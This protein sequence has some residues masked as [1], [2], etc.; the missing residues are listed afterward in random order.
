MKNLF[1]GPDK[2]SNS[3]PSKPLNP[4][5]VKHQKAQETMNTLSNKIADMEEQLDNIELKCN[6]LTK[7]AKEKLKL[8]DKK[9]AKKA[10]AQKSKYNIQIKTIEGA[11]NMM[12]EQKGIIENMLVVGTVM[13]T[14]SE[15]NVVIQQGQKDLNIDKIDDMKDAIDVIHIHYK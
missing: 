5:E 6:Q 2:S 11:M 1:G 9:A 12:E 15:A 13:T 14:V 7:F 3:K 10:L 4:N 8:G